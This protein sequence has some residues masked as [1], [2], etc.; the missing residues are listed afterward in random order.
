MISVL[1]PT[2]GRPELLAR[3]VQSLVHSA[4]DPC[5]VEILGRFDDDDP[6]LERGL[7]IVDKATVG[8]PLGYIGMGVMYNELADQATGEWLLIFNDDA[9][10][11]TQG[12]DDVIEN[13]GT[14]KLRNLSLGNNHNRTE[15]APFPCVPKRWFEVCG[16]ITGDT[17][18][19]SW[20]QCVAQEAGCFVPEKGVEILHDR[21]DLTGNNDDETYRNRHID[22]SFFT[23]FN[24]PEAQAGRAHDAQLIREANA[25]RP[26]RS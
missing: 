26:G 19:D 9:L 3:A 23:N 18:V 6:M 5:G 25:R 12:W 8:A 14:L 13:Y 20:L 11:Q 17:R 22:P 21:F 16:R 1:I 7:E 24:T 4:S 2:R 15:L 10:M